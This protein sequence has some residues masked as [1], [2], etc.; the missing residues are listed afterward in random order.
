MDT[1]VGETI[2]HSN[3]NGESI[4][5]TKEIARQWCG[6]ATGFYD[7][8]YVITAYEGVEVDSGE[9]RWVITVTESAPIAFDSLEECAEEWLASRQVTL[10][11]RA[12]S[13]LGH[14]ERLDSWK[15]LA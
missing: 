11:A 5:I 14:D 15:A 6:Q 3:F 8:A 1:Q 10:E 2:S 7:F 4:K 9:P 12:E 13:G